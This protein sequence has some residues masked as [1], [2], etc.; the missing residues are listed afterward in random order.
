MKRKKP[1]TATP[2]KSATPKRRR[3]SAQVNNQPPNEE[4]ADQLEANPTPQQYRSNKSNGH[5]TPS[6][7]ANSEREQEEADDG[8]TDD[9]SGSPTPRPNG[10]N[11]FAMPES[12]LDRIHTKGKKASRSAQRKSAN[13]LLHD[14]VEDDWEGQVGLARDGLDALEEEDEDDDTITLAVRRDLA[15]IAGDA[16]EVAAA[17]TP[18]KRRGRPKG[19]KTKRSPTPEGDLPPEERYF[20]QNRP[21]PPQISSNTLASLK[22]LTHDEY[23]QQIRKYGEH[24]APEKAYLV[25]LHARSFP[26]WRFELS[27]GYNVCLYGWGSKRHLVNKFAEWLH[28]RWKPSPKIVIVNGYTPKLNI[29]NILAVVAQAVTDTDETLRLVGQPQEMLDT[30]F[31]YISSKPLP[32]PMVIMVNS[33]DAPPLRRSVTQNI[34]A[35]LAAHPSI[36]LIATADTPTHGL[37]WNSTL[38]TQLNFVFHDCTTYASYDVELSV[39]DD[40]QELLGRKGRRIGGKEGIGFVLKSLPENARNLYRVLLTELLAILTD[41]FEG[42]GE[43]EMDGEDAGVTRRAKGRDEEVGIEYRRLY[44]KAS[45]EFICS[46]DMNFRFLLKEFHDHDMITS[47][48]DASGTELLGVPLGREEM[49][50]VLE[51]LVLAD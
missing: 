33:I 8:L 42:M 13:T 27:Q 49:E 18:T 35:R 47:R 44:Q 24:H 7:L 5:A 45:E 23:F 15:A 29:R 12:T 50:G 30:V 4:D 26:Q 31:A 1:D 37:L 21:G 34:I 28:G 20:F 14:E 17:E 32:I 39:V 22:L 38:K 10:H 51:D 11:L 2:T 36:N 9:G 25:K 16:L 41:G 43:E 48:R 19:S 46:S 6:N 3:T 40:V